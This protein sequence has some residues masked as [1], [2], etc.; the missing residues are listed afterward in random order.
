MDSTLY[1]RVYGCGINK[2]AIL[3]HTEYFKPYYLFYI[4]KDYVRGAKFKIES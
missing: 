1:Y 3:R 4:I 2:E